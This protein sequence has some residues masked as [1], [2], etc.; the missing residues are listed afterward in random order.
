MLF[1]RFFVCVL[2]IYIQSN[3]ASLHAMIS[4]A[5]KRP[6]LPLSPASSSVVIFADPRHKLFVQ[7]LSEGRGE[8]VEGGT[9]VLLMCPPAP[10][11]CRSIRWRTIHPDVDTSSPF[12]FAY[13]CRV[14]RK[15]DRSYFEGLKEILTLDHFFRLFNFN[16][17]VHLRTLCC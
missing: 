5:Y 13:L 1:P 3:V 16:L 10:S 11:F 6:S 7:L 15:L 14:V 8:W 9:N 4:A 12:S 2:V 17:R